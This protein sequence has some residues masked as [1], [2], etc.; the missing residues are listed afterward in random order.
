MWFIGQSILAYIIKDSTKEKEIEKLLKKRMSLIKIEVNNLKDEEI[1]NY[2][3]HPKMPD[4]IKKL[5]GEKITELEKS[6]FSTDEK[7]VES[8]TKIFSSKKTF[9]TKQ[10]KYDYYPKSFKKIIIDNLY[11]DTPVNLI[12]TNSISTSIKK[13]I[14]E[15][16]LSNSDANKLLA[17]PN[18]SKQLKEHIIENAINSEYEISHSIREKTIPEEIRKQIVITK[19][20]K[21]NIFE[22]MNWCFGDHINFIKELKS[23]ELEE[24][25][26][27]QTE[28]TV[29]DLFDDYKTPSF[30][31]DELYTRKSDIITESIKKASK[32]KI[33]DVLRKET[34]I[35]TVELILQYRSKDVFTILKNLSEY[36]VLSF[37]KL[38]YLPLDYKDFI[39]KNHE[40]AIA[41]K[42]NELRKT[43][44]DLYYLSSDSHIPSKIQQQIITQ[45]KDDI[46]KDIL[47]KSEEDILKSIKYSRTIPALAEMTIELR[48]NENN[49]LELL[50]DNY[51]KDSVIDMIIKKKPELILKY[52]ETQDQNIFFKHRGKNKLSDYALNK[53]IEIHKDYFIDKINKFNLDEKHELLNNLNTIDA[54]KKIIL[55]SLDIKDID[56][57]VCLELLKIGNSKLILSNFTKIK[58]FIEKSNISFESFIQ[59]GSGSQK[60]NNWLEN[61]IDIINNDQIKDFMVCKNYFFNYYY[62]DDKEKE[63]TVYTISNYL[64]LLENYNKYKDLCINLTNQ[65]KELSKE[66]KLNISFLFNINNITDN[67]DLPKTLEE[68]SK[69][70]KEI[71]EEYINI[72]ND[73]NT[74]HEEL[75]NIFNNLLLCN[76]N[77]IL[78]YIGGTGAL[79][80]LKLDNQNSNT[81]IRLVDELMNY[82]KIIEM[83]ND[84]NNTEGLRAIL[85]YTFKDID[86]LTK[87]QNIF[88]QFEKKVTKLYELDSKNNLTT[89]EKNKDLEGVLS[90]ELSLKYGGE[91]YD[92]SDKN[93]ALYAHVVS[94]RE[95]I[96]DLINGIASG[97]SNF[98]SVSPISYRGQKY[99]WNKSE[100][101]LAYDKIPNGSFVCSSINNMGSNS[102]INKN[103]SEV[104]PIKRIQRGILE[105]SSAT[106]NNA[107]A[108]LYREGL[109]P[110]GLILPEGREPTELELEYHKKYNLPFI[111]TQEI[112]KPIENPKMI[113]KRAEDKKVKSIPSNELDKIKE[114]IQT[115]TRINKENDEYTGREIAIITDCHSMYEPT[116]AALEDIRRN[117]IDE[118]YSLGDNTG[119]GPNPREVF[120]LLEEYNVKS[121]AG[122]SEY[123]HTLGTEPF[124]YFSEEKKASQE[125]TK[126]K[127]G[128]ERIKKLK[129]YPASI[130][131]LLGNKKIGLCHFANDVRWDFRDQST[132]TYRANYGDPDASKQFLYT[133][134]EESNKKLNNILT[135][136]KKGTP[137]MRGYQS[138]KNEPIFDGKKVTDYD[139]IIQGH[140]HFDMEDY[141]EDTDIYTL[142]AVGIGYSETDPKNEACYYVLRERKD[143]L[144]YDFEQRYVKFNRNNLLSNIYTSDIPNK[145]LILR[146]VKPEK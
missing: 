79:R 114:L 138:S 85:E 89:L 82:S 9:N 146:F 124:P 106:K 32:D 48:I 90:E 133:N 109:I 125:W 7:R 66:D 20:N 143:D 110:C 113:L 42:I 97:K 30:I 44:I 116:L 22:V 36:E 31:I 137:E 69:F 27:E 111:I 75:K 6:I 102:N 132:H 136:H 112:E 119:V 101:I 39:I 55:E 21:A 142:R 26:E 25:I 47:E 45:R 19:I 54:C 5:I 104:D 103:S 99:Y 17:N 33:S 77:I 51:A 91:V 16:S 105:T 12:L 43:E 68:L 94:R 74:T 62:D 10:L 84:T 144:G 60:H 52:L 1:V 13:A 86:T 29:I 126:E 46:V 128:P 67:V 14:I 98:I 2:L 93:Y 4:E 15:V 8:I 53:I 37:L 96:E 65:R 61:I 71:Y 135:S 130:D 3:L 24:I 58:S 40:K 64:E 129:L 23:K 95:N 139:A 72:I 123:Y 115:K 28:D 49:F 120:D 70:K 59:Y 122:N 57:N 80:T 88:S 73:E 81:I 131:I 108:L 41:K 134:S 100:L 11:K 35:K 83:V 121:I 76:S 18:V 141:L 107:E 38:K 118:I 78:E 50:T 117:G 63:N 92:Y 127:L 87:M 145:Q 34:S 56:V 140:V